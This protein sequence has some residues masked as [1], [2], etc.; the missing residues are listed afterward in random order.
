MDYSNKVVKHFVEAL[1]SEYGI[2]GEKLVFKHITK[3]YVHM[4]Y[5]NELILGCEFDYIIGPGYTADVV[6]L[7]IENQKNSR[8]E[9]SINE[10][11]KLTQHDKVFEDGIRLMLRELDLDIGKN[12]STVNNA[13]EI[14]EITKKAKEEN[15]KKDIED[16]E[17]EIL[18]Y[19]RSGEN[20]IVFHL[21]DLKSNLSREEVKSI[22]VKHFETKG[23]KCSV[24]G[25][26]T[27]YL[28]ISWGE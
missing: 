22:I 27:R 12:I 8:V 4:Y 20:S 1:K 6:S 16:L 26:Y 9:T 13:Q 15:I 7:L 19:A 5:D 14:I 18:R 2:D 21:N 25:S 24:E 3:D 23:F 17:N 10:I 28:K 11:S